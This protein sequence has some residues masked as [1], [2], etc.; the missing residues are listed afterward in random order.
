MTNVAGISKQNQDKN[1]S[2]FGVDEK[3]HFLSL[4]KLLRM[5]VYAL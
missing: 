4:R 3:K 1:E 2:L 5:S